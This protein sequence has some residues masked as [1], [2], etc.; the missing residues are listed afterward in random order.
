MEK[1]TLF[2]AR[3]CATPQRHQATG[4]QRHRI[5]THWIILFELSKFITRLTKILDKMPQQ[6]VRAA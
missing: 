5:L 1:T 6:L 2:P 3:F 4:L